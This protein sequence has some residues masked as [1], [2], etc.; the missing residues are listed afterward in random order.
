MSHKRTT[1]L[2]TSAQSVDFF[3]LVNGVEWHP[4]TTPQSPMSL[5][6]SLR[7]L[8][9]F[10]SLSA[11]AL[12]WYVVRP[13]TI[14]NRFV[15]AVNNHDFATAKSFVEGDLWPLSPT[16][17]DRARTVDLVYAEA[18]PREWTDLVKFERRLI[19]RVGCHS[20][21]NGQHVEWTED[22]DLVAGIM[23]IEIELPEFHLGA[24]TI[25]PPRPKLPPPTTMSPHPP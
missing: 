8:F 3:L 13:S 16:K 2:R 7:L 24:P 19:L 1:N 14:A 15:A 12:Y 21:T 4:R 17:H 9:I 5:R 18:F 22:T 10:L 11:F 20:D 6:F 23:G 25:Q